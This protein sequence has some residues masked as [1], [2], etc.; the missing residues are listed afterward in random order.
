MIRLFAKLAMMAMV[1]S[2]LVQ[3]NCRS[4]TSSG[5]EG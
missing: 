4:D 5:E 1:G 2:V 3:P